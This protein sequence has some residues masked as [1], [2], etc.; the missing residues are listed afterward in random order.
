MKVTKKKEVLKLELN[1]KEIYT[2]QTAL[3]IMLYE[4]CNLD[5]LFADSPKLYNRLLNVGGS[6][7]NKIDK[8]SLYSK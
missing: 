1:S 6:M 7:F 3:G 2:L 8:I 4:D 5:K